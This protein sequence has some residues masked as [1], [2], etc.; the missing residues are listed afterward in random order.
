[1]KHQSYQG[2]WEIPLRENTAHED[3]WRCYPEDL[4]VCFGDFILI[5]LSNSRRGNKISAGEDSGKQLTHGKHALQ[6][7]SI[8][9][10]VSHMKVSPLC[11]GK[12]LLPPG[13]CAQWSCLDAC[14]F[15]QQ[16]ALLTVILKINNSVQ[17]LEHRCAI[18]RPLGSGFLPFSLYCSNTLWSLLLTDFQRERPWLWLTS[19]I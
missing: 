10:K 14:P 3:A 9:S 6:S 1:M 11:L 4:S 5:M 15:L 7:P 2:A 8:F 17:C 13:I 19:S 18:P 12:G 16:L